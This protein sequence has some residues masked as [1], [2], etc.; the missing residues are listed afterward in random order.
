[1]TPRAAW[2]VARLAQVTPPGSVAPRTH[3]VGYGREVLILVFLAL[4]LVGCLIA[5]GGARRDGPD[6]PASTN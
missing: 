2:I 1:M 3:S 5:L 6:K 4:T